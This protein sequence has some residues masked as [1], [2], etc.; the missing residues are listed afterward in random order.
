MPKFRHRRRVRS[1]GSPSLVPSQPS[2][3]RLQ[4]RVA[5]R[6]PSTSTGCPRGDSSGGASVSSNS[7]AMADRS[8]CARNAAAVFSDAIRGY[9]DM[10]PHFTAGESMHRPR[11][12]FDRD[13]V[14]G[15]HRR[16]VAPALNDDWILEVL[17]QVID[18]FDHAPFHR[19]SYRDVVEHREMLHVFAQADAARVRTDGN[20]ELRRHEDDREVLVDAAETAA[21]DL[22]EVDGLRLKQL[23]EDDAVRAVLAGR[24][25]DADLTHRF[26]DRR[27]AQDVV[28]TRRL[29][30]P[31]E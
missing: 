19:A 6:T 20:P 29:L 28:W 10:G 14:T 21:V 11:R 27:V 22:T 24:D 5:T 15:F 13:A 12:G 1:L 31:P 4:T 23:F 26:C 8:R 16:Y 25:A 18:V 30:D 7:R 9:S 2:I 17:V 3:G